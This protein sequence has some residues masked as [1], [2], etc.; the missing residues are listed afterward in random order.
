MS[1]GALFQKYRVSRGFWGYIS[2]TASPISLVRKGKLLHL[3]YLFDYSSRL[4]K[5]FN[6]QSSLAGPTVQAAQTFGSTICCKTSDKKVWSTNT[7]ASQFWRPPSVSPPPLPQVHPI[8]TAPPPAPLHRLQPPT[9]TSSPSLH[10]DLNPPGPRLES[11]TSADTSDPRGPE[12]RAGCELETL[13]MDQRHEL[14]YHTCTH[15]L[16][17]CHYWCHCPGWLSLLHVYTLPKLLL[18]RAC[19]QRLGLRCIFSV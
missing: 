8:I 6:T 1:L 19:F 15:M 2:S 16:F 4:M 5:G 9:T 10:G 11:S 12:V 7:S 13:P 18:C 17:I 3:S 14:F